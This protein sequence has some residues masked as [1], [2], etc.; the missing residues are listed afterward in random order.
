MTSQKVSDLVAEF[1]ERKQIRKA[2]GII[3]SGNAHLFDSITARGY[4]EIVCV[5]HEQA[6]VMA[7]GAY[8]RI[9]GQLGACL[10]TTGAGSL[11]GITGVVSL[12]MDSIP[13]LILSGNENSKFTS[14]ENPLRI[15]GIQGYDSSKMVRDYTKY[16]ERVLKPQDLFVHLEKAVEASLEGRPGPTWVDIPM[17][18]QSS[19]VEPSELKE[20]TPTSKKN[21]FPNLESQVDQVIEAL[22]KSERP[23]IWLGHGIRLSG[24]IDLIEP[25][26]KKSNSPALVSWAGL[27]MIDSDHPS[28]F[29]RAGLYGQ[30]SANLVLQN[31]DFLLTIGTRLAI[32]QIGYEISELARDAKTLAVVDIDISETKKY[33]QRINLPIESDARQFMEVFLKKIS[34]QDFRQKYKPWWTKCFDLKKNFP[35]IGPEHEDREGFINSYPVLQRFSNYLSP[36]AIVVTDMGTAL[37][38]G[39]Q[40]MSFKKGQRM[41]TSTGLGEMGY[42]LPAAIGACFANDRKDVICL[43]CDG[44]MMMNLQELQTIA[45]HRLPIKIIIFNNDGYLMIKHTQKSLFKGRYSGTNLSSGVSCPDFKKLAQAFNFPYSSVK[46]WSDFEK[47]IPQFLKEDGPAFCEIYM[48]P[49]QPLVPKLSL[50]QQKDGTIVSP[51]LE[52][53]SPFISRKRLAEN[54][55]SGLHPKSL[56]IKDS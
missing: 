31:C 25:L 27:D 3:G 24:A 37:L 34:T 26:L 55:I 1:L 49:E 29:G 35:W 19:L 10:L 53:L 12:W 52:D 8:Y 39:H 36:D 2:F 41:M 28:I 42:G 15:W 56:Q 44:G 7:M 5:H 46:T 20:P 30:R 9:S 16:A 4:T 32:P 6:A 33:P 21:L 17:N 40:V 50:A 38:S 18:I 48:H 54:M 23:L 51:P 13:G 11:N 47:N 45:H 14:P 43:N 22:S